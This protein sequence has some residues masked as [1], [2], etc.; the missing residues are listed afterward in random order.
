MKSPPADAGYKRVVLAKCPIKLRVEALSKM[1]SPSTR[2]LMRLIRA[3]DTPEKLRM[4]ASNRL[5]EK[6]I[7]LVLK[8]ERD[9]LKGQ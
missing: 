1:S 5:A 4:L 7:D 3:K 2:L 8:S 9:R 6:E